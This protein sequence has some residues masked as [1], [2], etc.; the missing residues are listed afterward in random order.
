MLSLYFMDKTVCAN[1]TQ[2]TITFGKLKIDCG[3]AFSRLDL[4]MCNSKGVLH[5]KMA[6]LAARVELFCGALGCV[7]SPARLEIDQDSSCFVQMLGSAGFRLSRA[8]SA[9][10]TSTS[11]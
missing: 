8:T 6:D 10:P 1:N 3:L 7:D 9:A 11:R 4:E 2:Q 5:L